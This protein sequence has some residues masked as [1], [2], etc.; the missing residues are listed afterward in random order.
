MDRKE[1]ETMV[2]RTEESIVD[3]DRILGS[4]WVGSLRGKEGEWGGSMI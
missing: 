1:S 3:V 2:A 4:S